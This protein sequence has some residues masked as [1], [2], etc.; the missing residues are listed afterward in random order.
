[1][2]SEKLS[3]VTKTLL[4]AYDGKTRISSISIRLF[5]SLRDIFLAKDDWRD[6][7]AV[8]VASVLSLFVIVGKQ[9]R[10]TKVCFGLWLEVN[11]SMRGCYAGFLLLLYFSAGSS[12]SF[13]SKF[14]KGR[15]DSRAV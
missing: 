5:I 2:I 10:M 6:L 14:Y 3:A 4:Y 13:C 15:W 11:V 7:A 1:M 12:V 9:Y 8:F